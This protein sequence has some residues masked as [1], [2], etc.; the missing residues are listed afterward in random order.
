MMQVPSQVV[1]HSG[2]G[3]RLF[4][5]HCVRLRLEPLRAPALLAWLIDGLTV[6]LQINRK[7]R[8]S[9][10]ALLSKSQ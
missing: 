10:N 3:G 1:E 7:N 2:H 6:F 5:G 9:H 4:S 8:L